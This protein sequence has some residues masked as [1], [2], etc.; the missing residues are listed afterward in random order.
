[1]L[2]PKYYLYNN[3]KQKSEH[4]KCQQKLSYFARKEGFCEI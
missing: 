2:C 3:I 4:R 1:M